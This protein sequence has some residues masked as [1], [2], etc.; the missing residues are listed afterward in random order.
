MSIASFCG[1]NSIFVQVVYVCPLSR[2]GTQLPV[3][4]SM[5][6]DSGAR[7]SLEITALYMQRE[8]V[9]TIRP[10]SGTYVEI[11]DMRLV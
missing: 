9:E 4:I 1:S 3:A 6:T 7:P 8:L 2:G 5:A 11:Y 10:V